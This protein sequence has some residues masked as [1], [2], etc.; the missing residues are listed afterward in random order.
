[1]KDGHRVLYGDSI[2][3]PKPFYNIHALWAYRA[4]PAKD[5]VSSIVFQRPTF[6]MRWGQLMT[7]GHWAHEDP[8]LLRFV[9]YNI[10]IRNALK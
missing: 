2:M 8:R 7:L 5:E 6:T 1:M 3:G 9:Y 10:T 4:I